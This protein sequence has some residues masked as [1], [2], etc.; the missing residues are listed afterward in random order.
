MHY[1]PWKGTSYKSGYV[2]KLKLLILGH[3]HYDDFNRNATIHWTK[4]HFEKPDRFWLHVEQVVKGFPLDNTQRK[5]FWNSVA[6]A[7][8]IQQALERNGRPT[9]QQWNEA[10]NSFLQL[11]RCT[12]PNLV[13]VFSTTVWEHLPDAQDQGFSGS[14]QPP[15][16]GARAYLY[17]TPDHQFLAGVFN[18]P[19][20]PAKSRG[21]WHK[22]A[23]T[24]I[25]SARLLR[26][27]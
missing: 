13:F 27:N 4:K 12:E 24:L 26:H 8:F 20:N 7:N 17:Q 10:R 19:R 25:E 15:K 5:S 21:Y 1:R 23:T 22:W 6:F 18:H 11:V 14:Y 2:S 3:S 9:K 16:L